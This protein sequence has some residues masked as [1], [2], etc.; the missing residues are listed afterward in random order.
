METLVDVTIKSVKPG[1]SGETEHGLWQIHNIY[2]EGHKEKFTYFEKDGEMI[3]EPGMKIRVF[4]YESEQ[5]GKYM[6]HT[7][8][9][10]TYADG[11]KHNPRTD[12]EIPK[13]APQGIP[14]PQNDLGPVSMYVSYHKDYVIAILA[15]VDVGEHSLENFRDSTIQLA[16]DFLNASIK[17]GLRVTQVPSAQPNTDRIEIPDDPITGD[18]PPGYMDGPTPDPEGWDG[19]KK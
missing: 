8:K 3:P 1:P 17:A 15:K 5:K 2:L 14:A 10:L 13:R 16:D 9:R 11:Q 18:E 6:N 4:D 19:H 7:I 12:T